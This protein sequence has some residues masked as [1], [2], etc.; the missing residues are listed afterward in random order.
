MDKC[1][2]YISLRESWWRVYSTESLIRLIR[3]QIELKKYNK[4]RK[5]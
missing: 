5:N 4:Y 1:Q 3:D 2:N